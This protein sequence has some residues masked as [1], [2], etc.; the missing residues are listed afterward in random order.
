MVSG[1]TNKEKIK[2]YERAVRRGLEDFG[3]VRKESMN[4]TILKLRKR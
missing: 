3:D 1:G 2:I 4:L